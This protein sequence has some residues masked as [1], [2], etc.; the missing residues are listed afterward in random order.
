VEIC[1][2]HDSIGFLSG[3]CGFALR[4]PISIPNALPPLDR[5]SRRSSLWLKKLLSRSTFSNELFL[6]SEK[7]RSVCRDVRIPAAPRCLCNLSLE[8]RCA[9]PGVVDTLDCR[10]L[11]FP[12]NRRDV[13]LVEHLRDVV[14]LSWDDQAICPLFAFSR[15][16]LC[17]LKSLRIARAFRFD[18]PR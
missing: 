14:G 6:Y 10:K 7:T 8:F 17:S 18:K 5:W 9:I 11:A 2:I 1:G 16:G 13:G 15:A 3:S 12:T 4:M